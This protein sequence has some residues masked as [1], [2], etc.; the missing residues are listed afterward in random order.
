MG[1][2]W[3]VLRGQSGIV[4]RLDRLGCHRYTYQRRGCVQS[5]NWQKV[6][7]DWLLVSWVQ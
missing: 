3:Q 6:I 4:G 1:S 5:R 2:D 7:A